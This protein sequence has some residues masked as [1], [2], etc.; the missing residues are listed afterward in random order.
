MV[1]T[2]FVCPFFVS[3]TDAIDISRPAGLAQPQFFD[4]QG[5][6]TPAC[7]FCI[8]QPV[9]TVLQ[10][11]NFEYYYKYTFLHKN[12]QERFSSFFAVSTFCQ[13]Q[14]KIFTISTDEQMLFHGLQMIYCTAGCFFR[15]VLRVQKTYYCITRKLSKQ[16]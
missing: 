9:L 11:D 8:A 14:H 15:H 2:F 5:I 6:T 3:F 12:F 10:L 4:S 1:Q 13:L 16:V 7:R